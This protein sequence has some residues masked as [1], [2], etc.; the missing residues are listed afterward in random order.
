MPLGI[1]VGTLG[2][3]VSPAAILLLALAAPVFAESMNFLK[4]PLFLGFGGDMSPPRMLESVVE[5]CHPA[6][7]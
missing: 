5:P 4:N 6:C 3:E 7:D 2:L 1:L